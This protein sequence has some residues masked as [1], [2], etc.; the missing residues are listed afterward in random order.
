MRSPGWVERGRSTPVF[1]QIRS[2]ERSARRRAELREGIGR[3]AGVELVAIDEDAGRVWIRVR[4]VART[5]NV[6]RALVAESLPVETRPDGAIGL[7]F[8]PWFRQAELTT[9]VLCVT[10]VAHHLA[11]GSGDAP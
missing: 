1:A 8:E 4:D 3:V 10:K 9:V 2:A 6:A 7:P 11:L 5:A